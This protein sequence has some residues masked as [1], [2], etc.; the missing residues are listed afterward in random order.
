MGEEKEE[1]EEGEEGE[2]GG[3]IRV[4]HGVGDGD[5]S[6]PHPLFLVQIGWILALSCKDLVFIILVFV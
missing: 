6:H 2:G 5:S 1:E 4:C 3:W